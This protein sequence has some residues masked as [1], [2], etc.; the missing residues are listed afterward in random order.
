MD[1]EVISNIRSTV[2]LRLRN[3]PKDLGVPSKDEVVAMIDVIIKRMHE[4]DPSLIISDEVKEAAIAAV[5]HENTVKND[6]FSVLLGDVANH[7]DWLTAARSKRVL[8]M[9]NSLSK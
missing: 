5:L 2:R 4:D 7:V 9:R 6:E 8:G 3:R 1:T